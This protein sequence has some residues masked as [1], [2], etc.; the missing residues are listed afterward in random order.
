MDAQD[1]QDSVWKGNQIP[2]VLCIHV[3]NQMLVIRLR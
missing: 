1:L 3:K 2:F